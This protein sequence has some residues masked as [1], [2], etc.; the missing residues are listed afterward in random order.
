MFR[1]ATSLF[2]SALLLACSSESSGT[3]ETEDGERGSY[4]IDQQSGETV[5]RI[6]TDDGTAEMRSGENVP[7]NLPAGF[8]LYPGASVVSNTTF[9][10][11]DAKG[12]LVIM[13]SS[14]TP[15]ELSGFYRQ[16]AEKAG[17]DIQLELS[18]EGGKMIG[19]ESEDGHSFSF[20]ANRESD[21]TTA[22]L[23]VGEK[24]RQ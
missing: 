10:Q 3:F 24:M 13:T 21:E 5:A 15:E 19:G 16:Q 12:S 22:Q 11:A 6:T 23:M 17:I 20:N 18:V 9:S 1:V 7:V 8:S 2:V 14:A 4:S